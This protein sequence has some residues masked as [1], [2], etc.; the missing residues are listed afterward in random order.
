MHKRITIRFNRR[1]FEDAVFYWPFF[2]SDIE[3]GAHDGN[4]FIPY[5]EENK[6]VWPPDRW[7]EDYSP[8][9]KDFLIVNNEFVGW[10]TNISNISKSEWE[11]LNRKAS[12]RLKT[13]LIEYECNAGDA[14]GNEVDNEEGIQRMK[15]ISAIM[16]GECI[17]ETPEIKPFLTLIDGG[18]QDA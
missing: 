5:N 10:V 9:K 11:R 12:L 14:W 15:Q 17:I 13:D 3:M 16:D 7:W 2:D 18:K 8:K 1:Y 4:L 6:D